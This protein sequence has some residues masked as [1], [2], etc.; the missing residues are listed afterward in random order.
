MVLCV[1]PLHLDNTQFKE[2]IGPPLIDFFNLCTLGLKSGPNLYTVLCVCHIPVDGSE[3]PQRFRLVQSDQSV[4]L[5]FAYILNRWLLDREKQF[6]LAL[7]SFSA[8]TSGVWPLPKGRMA[9]LQRYL[10]FA[11]TG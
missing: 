10:R 7:K 8:V 6:Q 1:V 3:T 4:Y 5:T 9:S 2:A 11:R